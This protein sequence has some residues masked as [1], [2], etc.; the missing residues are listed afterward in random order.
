MPK[1][2]YIGSFKKIWDEEGVARGLEANGCSVI[3]I[4]EQGFRYQDYAEIKEREKPDYVLFAKLKIPNQYREAIARSGFCYIPD[5]YWGLSRQYRILGDHMFK[6]RAILSPDGGNDDKWEDAGIRHRLLRQGI[7]DEY[8]YQSPQEKTKD[9]VFIGTINSQYPYRT[10]LIRFL[11]ST[12]GDRFHWYGKTNTDEK[13]GHDLNELIGQ[14][15]IVIGESV[16]S[17]HYWSNRIYETTGRGGFIIHPT[18]PGLDGEFEPYKEFMPYR[19]ND[20]DGLKDIIEYYLKH[21]EERDRI[22][23]AGFD[24]CKNYTLQKRCNQLLR[25][26]G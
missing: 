15:K 25:Y 8:Y 18:I 12:Y 21:D 7:A 10:K 19:H 5:L 16:Y 2:L 1:I 26:I 6:A 17:P 20:F 13:R 14:T 11:R 23:R 9:I 22:A 4:E 3:R 24:R